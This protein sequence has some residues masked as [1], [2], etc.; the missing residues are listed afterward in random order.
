MKIIDFYKNCLSSTIQEKAIYLDLINT[1]LENPRLE[2]F[3][4]FLYNKLKKDNKLDL[5]NRRSKTTLF[6]NLKNATVDSLLKK[7]TIQKLKNIT[8]ETEIDIIFLKSCALNG[9]IYNEHQ[10][11]TGC[12]I[13]ILIRYRDKNKFID[14]LKEIAE[15]IPSVTNNPFEELYEET[16][17]LKSN[18]QYIDLHF[19]ISNPLLFSVNVDELFEYSQIHPNYKNKNLRILSTEHSILHMALHM[20]NDADFSC[21][22][23]F[24]YLMMKQSIEINEDKLLNIARKWQCLRTFKFIQSITEQTNNH[25]HK[26]K[27]KNEFLKKVLL[28]YSKQK[29]LKRRVKQF[30]ALVTLIDN[31][32]TILN[33]L[34][35][36]LKKSVN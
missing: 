30:I 18:N 36:Y 5:L 24:D 16:W 11:R 2:R 14:Q 13:D 25:A 21:H 31:T 26:P 29:S 8:E 33:F 27:M 12:D 22:S 23:M 1:Y 34:K 6:N 35:V 9:W 4:F 15:K 3:V 20:Y 10:Y 19:N 28:G 7:D 17:K 32:S